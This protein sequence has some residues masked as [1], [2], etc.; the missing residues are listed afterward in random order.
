MEDSTASLESKY[1]GSPRGFACHTCYDHNNESLL[2]VTDSFLFCGFI[3][4]SYSQ[5]IV[6]YP[7]AMLI[8][9][10]VLLLGCSLVG[11]LVGPL[12]NFSDP[13]LVSQFGRSHRSVFVYKNIQSNI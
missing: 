13:L 5:V 11:L 6:D 9:C 8:G 1:R 3:S 2:S 12:P 4:G 10:A 7:L